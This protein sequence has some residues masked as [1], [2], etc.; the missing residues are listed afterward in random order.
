MIRKSCTLLVLLTIIFQVPAQIK[1]SG[2]EADK[3]FKGSTLII[4]AKSAR[5]PTFIQMGETSNYQISEFNTITRSL[6][7]LGEFDELKEAKKGKDYLGFVHH[8]FNQYYKD[9]PVEGAEYVMHEKNSRIITLDG[10]F[11]DSINVNTETVLTPAQGIDAAMKAC[12]A[13][14]YKW[15]DP[16]EEAR[17]RQSRKD[18]AATWYP[19][20]ELC[21]AALNLDLKTREMHLCYRM[22]LSSLEPAAN[23]LVFIDARTG[24][25]IG[26]K[27]LV[28]KSK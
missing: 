22:H 20:P 14:K 19:V 3:L 28:A 2:D 26:R 25:L 8:H 11:V 15:E 7:H 5:V 1:Y 10:F 21:I 16:Q 27:T 4:I 17:L 12:G 23:E 13:R 24:V 9:I 6:L 18:S